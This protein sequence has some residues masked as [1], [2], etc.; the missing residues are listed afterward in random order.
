M[1]EIVEWRERTRRGKCLVYGIDRSGNKWSR[2]SRT[3]SGLDIYLTSN[4]FDVHRLE[5]Y[6]IWLELNWKPFISQ[7]QFD[8]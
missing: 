3:V 5:M 7:T 1:L 2:D 4:S 8:Q 6:D